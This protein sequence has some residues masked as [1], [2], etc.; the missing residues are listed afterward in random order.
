MWRLVFS[1]FVSSATAACAIPE[2]GMPAAP[3]GHHCWD[4]GPQGAFLRV[5]GEQDR[6][7]ASR[8]CQTALERNA[9]NQTTNWYVPGSRT[10][11]TVTPVASYQIDDQAICREYA[12]STGVA[13]GTA[14]RVAA[15]TGT[16]CRQADGTWWA[17]PVPI[18]E[19]LRKTQTAANDGSL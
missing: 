6:Q 7:Y 2:P 13:D 11:G 10:L 16:A 19:E 18:P 14:K 9:D 4:I 3:V 15:T 1:A 8:A 5:A 12:V 17:W